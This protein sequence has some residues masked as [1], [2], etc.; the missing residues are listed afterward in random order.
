[1]SEFSYRNLTKNKLSLEKNAS[2][3]KKNKVIQ[4]SAVIKKYSDKNDN[5]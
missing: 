4:N 2:E 5:S 1:M 3:N